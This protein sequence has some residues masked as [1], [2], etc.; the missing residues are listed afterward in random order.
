MNRYQRI[1]LSLAAINALLML[2]FPPFNNLPLARGLFPSFDGFYPLLGTWGSKPVHEGLLFLEIV[3]LSCN[4]LAAWLVLQHRGDEEIPQFRFIPGIALFAAVNALLVS[5][6]PPFEPYSG[7]TTSGGSFDSFYFVFGDRSHRAI[8][9]PLLQLEYLWIGIN[10]LSLMLLFG[11]VARHDQRAREQI[12][13]LADH[14]PQAAVR[15]LAHELEQ[16]AAAQRPS[17]PPH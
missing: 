6:F 16:R 9:L 14:L 1:V 11:A 17:P 10:A 2:L 4:T 13:D 3:W 8:F 7:I 15:Q 5:L 12:L